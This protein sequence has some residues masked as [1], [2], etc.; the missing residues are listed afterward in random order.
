MCRRCGLPY[1][2][3]TGQPFHLRVNGHWY[4]ISYPKTDESPVVEHFSSGAHAELHM[5][6]ITIDLVRSR[7]MSTKDPRE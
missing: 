2:S 4:D 5:A 1:V 6:V 3:E 7:G